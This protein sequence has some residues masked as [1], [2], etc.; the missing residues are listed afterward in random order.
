MYFIFL[1]ANLSSVIFDIDL[2]IGLFLGDRQGKLYLNLRVLGTFFYSPNATLK[3]LNARHFSS[4]LGTR[5]G[6]KRYYFYRFAFFGTFYGGPVF[7]FF[8]GLKPHFSF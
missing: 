4:F 5:W 3:N 8:L 7:N 6:G 1:G 2:S